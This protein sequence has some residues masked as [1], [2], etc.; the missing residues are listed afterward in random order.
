MVVTTCL[1]RNGFLEFALLLDTKHEVT[2]VD[3]FH[4]EIESVLHTFTDVHNQKT[5]L[6]MLQ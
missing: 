5:L 2:T 6:M 3:E 4:D 1:H